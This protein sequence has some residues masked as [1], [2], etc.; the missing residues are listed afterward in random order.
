MKKAISIVLALI[1]MFSLFVPASATAATVDTAI[2]YRGIGVYVN[3]VE[4][5]VDGGV[6]IV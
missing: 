3:G 4:I 6:Q 2:T 5:P 1:L